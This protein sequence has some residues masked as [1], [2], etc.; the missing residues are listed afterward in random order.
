MALKIFSNNWFLPE[1]D[2]AY[3]SSK[4]FRDESMGVFLIL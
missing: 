1:S 3:Y 2:M 4:S